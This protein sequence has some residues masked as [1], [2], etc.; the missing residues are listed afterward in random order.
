[1]HS[2]RKV[3]TALAATLKMSP[4]LTVSPSS[5]S[6]NSI[7]S[8]HRFT[9]HRELNHRPTTGRP[10]TTGRL[11]TTAASWLSIKAGLKI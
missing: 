9:D 3:A 6:F 8:Q 11:P 7:L 5:I 10:P 4:L 2:S 1:M